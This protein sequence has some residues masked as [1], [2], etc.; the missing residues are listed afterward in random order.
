MVISVSSIHR[1][2]SLSQQAYQ[3]IRL[4]IRTGGLVQNRLYSEGELA[5]TMGISRTPVRE[6]LI[7]LARERMVEIVPQRGFRIRELSLSEQ[8]EVFELR[9]VLESFAVRQLAQDAMP[10]HISRLKQL[11]QKQAELLDDPIEFLVIDEQFHLLMP[12][13]V[14]LERTYEMLIILR[15]AM[16]LIGSSALLVG[17]RTRIVLDEHAAIVRAVEAHDP[18]A[19]A[20]AM[21]IHLKATAE[22][23]G[24]LS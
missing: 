10:D 16:W 3:A 24:V 11:L 1:P 13:M 17:E 9:R 2:A 14:N 18:D 7:E 20:E 5:K 12:Q 22:A 19:A 8:Q 21:R 4:A 23:A 15:G 6:A